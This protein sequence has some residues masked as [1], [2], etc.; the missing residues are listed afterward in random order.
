MIDHVSA[1]WGLDENM[2]MYR[3]N[4][5]PPNGDKTLKLPTVN[6]TIQNSI[7]SEALDTYN[8]SFGSTIGGY[9]STFHHNLWA[10]NTGR[11]PSVGMI[12]DFT[13]AN[14]VIFNWCH[15]T[16]D[17]GGPKSFYS[18]IN[19]YFKPG[20]VTPVDQPI[21][22]RIIKPDGKL[23]QQGE[24]LFGKVY[25]S[26]NIVEG[27]PAVTE[28]NWAGG[29]QVDEEDGHD[30]K[31]V[32]PLIKQDKPYPH[33][34]IDV[35]SAQDAY[36]TVLVGA[37]AALPK[38]DAVDERIIEQ[39]RTSRIIVSPQVDPNSLYQFE[40][41]R[42]GRDSYLK[43]IITDIRLVGGYPEYKGTPY[44]DMD[45]DG[46]PDDWESKYG[47]DPKD[48]SDASGDF[49]GDGYTNIEDFINGLAPNAPKIEWKTPRTFIDIW[50]DAG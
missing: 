39:V 24:S 26:G 48:A 14:N 8:H 45:G 50:K 40:H 44:R 25:A 11:N 31:I 3:H 47:L 20:P 49:N 16:T 29:V 17:G 13:F 46:M 19:N 38:R 6:I 41:R 15:R 10:D 7:F 34:Y 28:D 22:Y 12:Y 30:P 2:S 21:R 36:Q 32:L 35:Q 33:A 9:N 23:T 18:M 4:Y 37:G 43:G 27:N 5:T 1:S 42:L